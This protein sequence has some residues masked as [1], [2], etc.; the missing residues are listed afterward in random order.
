M[1]ILLAIVFIVVALFFTVWFVGR[2][3]GQTISLSMLP[4]FLPGEKV[5]FFKSMVWVWSLESE[6][7]RRQWNFSLPPLTE[8]GVYVTDRRIIHVTY[9]F[10]IMKCDSSAW[11]EGKAG[12]DG[13]DFVKE[14]NIGRHKTFGAYLEIVSKSI[15]KQWG[16]PAQSQIRLFMKDPESMRQVIAE[17]IKVSEATDDSDK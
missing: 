8:A 16:R 7:T 3:F 14:A 2:I 11:F 4:S 15:V 6:S 17:M 10:R 5:L 9:I 13:Y 12:P 1:E